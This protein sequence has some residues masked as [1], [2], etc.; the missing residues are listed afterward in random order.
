M[1]IPNTSGYTIVVNVNNLNNR[2]RKVI[3]PVIDGIDIK[4]EVA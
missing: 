1:I 2:V 4:V 3:P